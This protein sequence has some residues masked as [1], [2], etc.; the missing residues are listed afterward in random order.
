MYSHPKDKRNT[1]ILLLVAAVTLVAPRLSAQDAPKP[2]I[3]AVLVSGGVAGMSAGESESFF[4][5][6]KDKLSQFPDLAVMLKADFGKGLKKEDKAALDKCEDVACIQSLAAKSGFQRVLLLRVT[7]K[8]STYQ[9]QSD[10]FDVKRPQKLSGIT[11]NAVCASADEVNLFIRKAAIKVGQA[12]THDTSVPE[13][14]QESRSKLWWYVGS[15]VVVG[16]AVGVY[17]IVEHKKGSSSTP[18]SLP[19]PPNFP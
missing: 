13:G 18:S 15:A 6:F 12:V 8:N 4:S 17:F 1:T 2:S 10:E 14:L 7:K 5:S 19:L 9:L 11:D 3:K 16:V